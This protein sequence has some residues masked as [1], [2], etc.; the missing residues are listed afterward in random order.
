MNI[1]IEHDPRH[2]LENFII[3][4]FHSEDTPQELLSELDSMLRNESWIKD[5]SLP[6]LWMIQQ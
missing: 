5:Q 2:G 4:L 6:Y 1:L 3:E